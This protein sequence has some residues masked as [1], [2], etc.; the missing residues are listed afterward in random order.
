MLALY[1]T[2]RMGLPRPFWA[3][4][5]TYVVASPLSGT[6]RSKAVFRFAGTIAGAIFTVSVVPRLAN[7]PELLSLA[8][9]C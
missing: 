8:L 5:T 3:M 7:A 6:A 1:F 2:L 4:M 9:A